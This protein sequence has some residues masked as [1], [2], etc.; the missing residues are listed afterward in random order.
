ML[1]TFTIDPDHSEVGFSVRHLLTRTRGLFRRFTGTVHL[2]RE[3][4]ERSQVEFRVEAASIDTRQNDRDVHLRGP[5]FFDVE[6]YPEITFRS[7]RMRPMDDR[8]FEVTGILELRGIA[9]ELVIPVTFHG[10]TL[11]PWGHERAGF[12]TEAVINRKEFGM[13]WNV[14]LD[15]GGFVLGDDVTV[16]LEFETIR[17]VTEVAA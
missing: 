10:I 8:R 15:A 7:S 4:P 11:D 12:S 1:E 17:R 2:D 16:T 14:P 3:R 9:R 13:R 5:D 6:R